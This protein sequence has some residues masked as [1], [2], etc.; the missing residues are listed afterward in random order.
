MCVS[1]G[2]VLSV[3]VQFGSGEC[4]WVQCGGAAAGAEGRLCAEEAPSGSLSGLS[5]TLRSH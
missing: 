5:H 3:L 1:S 4:W 2:G